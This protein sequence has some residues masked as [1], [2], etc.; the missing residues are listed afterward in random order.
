MLFLLLPC[1]LI[2]QELSVEKDIAETIRE[3]QEK[4]NIASKAG[5]GTTSYQMRQ[6]AIKTVIGEKVN[7]TNLEDQHGELWNL[8]VLN[9]PF[10]VHGISSYH[11]DIDDMKIAAANEIA[12]ENSTELMTFLLMPKPETA[13]D[14]QQLASISDKIVVVFMEMTQVKDRKAGDTRLLSL[15]NGFPVTYYIRANREIAGIKLGTMRARPKEGNIGEVTYEDAH[16]RNLKE[17]RKHVRALL[18]GKKI[19]GR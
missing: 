14:S 11:T 19:K 8:G 16:K 13:Q 3:Y 17:L 2:A 9:Q 12:E 5:D 18:R 1:F 4:G 15:L 6:L 10:V 7:P